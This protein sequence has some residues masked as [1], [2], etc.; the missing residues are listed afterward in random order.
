MN[1][2]HTIAPPSPPGSTDELSGWSEALTR[3]LIQHAA[4]NAP[5]SLSER[6]EEEW[7]ADLAER[8][9]SMARLRFGVGC[10]WATRVIVHEY[11]APKVLATLSATGNRVMNAYAQQD[12]SLFSRRTLAFVLI[13]GVHGVLIL[14]L[15]NGLAHGFIKVIPKGMEVGW[16]PEAPKNQPPPPLPPPPQFSPPVIDI[17]PTE[18]PVDFPPDDTRTIQ[19]VIAPPV[20]QLPPPSPSPHTVSRVLG[21]PGKAFP[22]TDDFYP[23]DAIR[24]GVSGVATV[25]TCVDDRGRLTAAPTLAQT[26]GSASL[27]AGALK[28]AKAG[29]GHYRA[30]TEDGHPVSSCYEFRVRFGFKN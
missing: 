13:V 25:R 30:T 5:Q 20:E 19:A 14:V 22:N 2:R 21:G 27:D 18:V 15:A 24:G 1:R 4:R 28:L 17:P 6:L 3:W 9:G 12:Y 16:V 26:S 7:L 8:R 10:C 11:S 29:S 23:P